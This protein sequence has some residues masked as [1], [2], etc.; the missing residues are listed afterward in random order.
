MSVINIDVI[1]EEVSPFSGL[2]KSLQVVNLDGQ[3]SLS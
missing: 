3:N 1:L 2:E